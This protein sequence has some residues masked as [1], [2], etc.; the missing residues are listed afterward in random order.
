[1]HCWCFGPP[2]FTADGPFLRPPIP[3]SPSLPTTPL[4]P[5]HTPTAKPHPNRHTTPQSAQPLGTSTKLLVS[6]P[7][8][9]PTGIVHPRQPPRAPAQPATH[10]KVRRHDWHVE[11]V[12]HL[13]AAAG[14]AAED[15]AKQI[16]VLR[17]RVWCCVKHPQSMVTQV[18]KNKT[19]RGPG[20]CS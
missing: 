18:W 15:Q 2:L 9:T 19:N 20:T 13:L 7:P 5:N 14:V 3:G 10:C 8:L 12:A 4:P 6:P 11:H 17:V 16:P 1:M